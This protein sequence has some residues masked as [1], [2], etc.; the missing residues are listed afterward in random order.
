M[1]IT[2]SPLKVMQ[3][4]SKDLWTALSVYDAG[5]RLCC[6]AIAVAG[7]WEK[8]VLIER[9]VNPKKIFVT[10]NPELDAS[11]KLGNNSD[12]CCL[13]QNLGIHPLDKV[14]LLLTS[15]KVEHGHWNPNMRS[16]F[17]T[18]VID[19]LKPLMINRVRLIIKI[20]PVENLADYRRIIGSNP[21]QVILR[22]DID[23][24]DIIK[25][26]DVVVTGYSTTVLEANSLHKPVVLVNTFGEPEYLP[27]VEMGLA[28]G[29]YRLV[30]LRPT[31]EKMLYNDS[32]R[33]SVIRN[34]DLFVSENRESFD[35][36]AL[37]RLIDLILKLGLSPL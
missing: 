4:M 37:Q 32:T 9:G 17:I 11:S 30:E 22:K 29:V 16:I 7:N 23:L 34:A 18:N 24:F 13:R 6:N 31:V 5:G 8:T 2:K 35:G 25:I 20:H 3:S 1:S 14:V 15:A 21:Q 19:A 10:G 33:N 28:T 12:L 26:S 27:Y 36:G